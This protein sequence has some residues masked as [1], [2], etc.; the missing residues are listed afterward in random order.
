M[1]IIA[2]RLRG[3]SLYHAPKEKITRPLKD[4]TR[5]SIFNLLMHSNKIS[6]QIEECSI[7][8]LYSGTGSFGLECMSRKA[9]NVCFVENYK[10][11]IKILQKNINKLKLKK[12]TKIFCDDVFNF[13][14]K[15][16]KR[17]L[18]SFFVTPLLKIKI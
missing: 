14:Q 12:N 3:S 18:I 10:P 11:S 13:V 2:G 5:E 7:L 6:F 4:L 9:K 15:K 16:I 1:R 8:D 17:N